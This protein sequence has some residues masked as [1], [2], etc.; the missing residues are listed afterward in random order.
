MQGAMA[1]QAGMTRL[2]GHQ[3]LLLQHGCDRFDHQLMLMAILAGLQQ[4]L[5]RLMLRRRSSQGITTQLALTHRQQ[6]LW[7]GPHQV[8]AIGEPP[9]EAAAAAMALAQALEQQL[10]IQRRLELQLLTHRQHQFAQLVITHQMQGLIHGLAVGP[11]PR[12]TAQQAGKR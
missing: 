8:T 1:G 7:R 5:W 12:A 10:G 4:L 11:M 3:S 2:A 9:E 6:P